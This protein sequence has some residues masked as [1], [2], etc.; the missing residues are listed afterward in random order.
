MLKKRVVSC[1]PKDKGDDIRTAEAAKFPVNHVV[2]TPDYGFDVYLER[3]AWSCVAAERGYMVAE[4]DARINDL[5]FRNA[6]P[7][8]VFLCPGFFDVWDRRL[9]YLI[10]QVPMR[11]LDAREAFGDDTIKADFSGSDLNNQLGRQDITH[12]LSATPEMQPDDEGMCLALLCWA[13]FDP[14][15]QEKVVGSRPVA[16]PYSYCPECGHQNA[17]DVAGLACPE[18]LRQSG[19]ANPLQMAQSEDFVADVPRFPMGRCF[20]VVFPLQNK[21]VRRGP[22]PS[23]PNG[24][25]LRM[26][27][28][29]FLRR[30]EHPTEFCGLSDTA[31]DASMQ[32]LSNQ[33]MER[34]RRQLQG[35]SSVI[36]MM[37]APEDAE[38]N[39][40]QL[41][42]DPIQSA[43]FPDPTAKLEV[44]QLAD[45]SSGLFNAINMV[46]EQFRSDLGTFELSANSASDLQGVAGVTVEQAQQAGSAPVEHF[47][48]RVSFALAC[49]YGVISDWLRIGWTEERWIRF[50]GPLGAADYQAVLGASIPNVDFVFS[51]GDEQNFAKKQQFNDAMQWY[52][53]GLP[54]NGG[55]PALRRALA[56]AGLAPVPMSIVDQIDQAEA[57]QAEAIAN[58]GAMQPGGPGVPGDAGSMGA[59]GMTPPG[60]EAGGPAGGG[61]DP[62][63]LAAMM[64]SRGMA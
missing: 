32:T 7:R 19:T 53:T 6:D 60:P 63:A 30:T 38:G 21:C 57:D 29:F 43:Y 52:Q 25:Q 31:V 17:P 40:L 18:C 33:L 61:L 10:E 14:E 2:T 4:W 13:Q 39:P 3:A 45:V 62:N 34:M 16:Q 37:G 11:V 56:V 23:G 24:E 28:Y 9:P 58:A 26:P 12:T 59:P 1:N 20:E 22:W 46:Q 54:Q 35:P 50:E 15:T 51:D 42:D 47:I 48:K 5:V 44:I 49:F 36:G 8:R 64:G 41:T 55:S 27:P